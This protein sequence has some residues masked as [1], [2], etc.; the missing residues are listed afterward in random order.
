M[1]SLNG[2]L[3]DLF[4]EIMESLN[5]S[6]KLSLNK[7]R[8]LVTGQ[9]NDKLNVRFRFVYGLRCYLMSAESLNMSFN[10]QKVSLNE[11][12]NEVPIFILG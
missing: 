1:T 8:I 7:I 3:N 12:L 9:I 4:N 5:D 6:F 11:S 10:L 2:C